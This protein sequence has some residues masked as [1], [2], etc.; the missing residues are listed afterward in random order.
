M[1]LNNALVANLSFPT[2][3]TTVT[4]EDKKI[5]AD[6]TVRIYTPSGYAGGKPVGLFSHG[7]GWVF[8]D[9]EGEDDLCRH[10]AKKAGVVVVSVDYR[11]APKHRYPAALDDCLAAYHWC[12]ENAS[13]LNTTPGQV[14]TIGG[15]AGGGLALSVALKLIDE[16]LGDSVKGVVSLVPVTVHPDACPAH[17]KSK[18]TAY[19]ENAEFTINTTS[20]MRAFFGECT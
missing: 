13:S 19:E 18:Y 20:A 3:D 12:M 16:G 11:L 9:L 17:L 1:A 4:A 8:G 2:P 14:F 6:V 15:S 5:S 10:V 7:G